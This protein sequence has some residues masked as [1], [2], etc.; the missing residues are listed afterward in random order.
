MHTYTHLSTELY[1]CMYV[2]MYVQDV[3]LFKLCQEQ[4]GGASAA[5][6]ATLHRCE[7]LCAL[8]HLWCFLTVV[9]EK[10]WSASCNQRLHTKHRH[11]VRAGIN[12]CAKTRNPTRSSE[13]TELLDKGPALCCKDKDDAFPVLGMPHKLHKTI[14]EE[15]FE[16][17][18]GSFFCSIENCILT[19]REQMTS[20]VYQTLKRIENNSGFIPRIGWPQVMLTR[21]QM[22]LEKTTSKI[23][24][25]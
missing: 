8:L 23:S 15:H 21:A 12:K 20:R 24:N 14:F 4:W 9:S 17:L 13:A 22:M 19:L 18:Q 7:A 16:F 3:R 2:C 25:T 10:A 11:W 6:A 1:V 5:V